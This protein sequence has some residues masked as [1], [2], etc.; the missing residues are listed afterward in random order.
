M[1]AKG[2][3]ERELLPLGGMA[4]SAKGAPSAANAKPLVFHPHRSDGG[5]AA[6][7]SR[8]VA[9]DVLFD[10]ASRGRYATDASIYQV[11]PVGVLVPKNIDDVRAAIA[12]CREHRGAG[13]PPRRGQLAVRTDGGRR[14][15]DRHHQASRPHHRIR[16][17]GDDRARRAGRRARS[18]QRLAETPRPVVPRRRQHIGAGDPRRHGGQQLL[19][20]PLDR[21][22][23]HGAQRARHRRGALRRH[24]GAVRTGTRDGRRFA[25]CRRAPPR[26]EG[27][28]SARARRNRAPR[29][30]G[31]APGRRLQHRRV[32][33]AER[34]AVHGRRQRQL[35]A[36]PGR[37]RG[38]ARLDARADA[39]ARA[40]A[41]APDAR[42]RQFPDAVPGDGMRAAPGRAAALRGRAGRPDDDRPG[43]R[44][45][46]V[47]RGHRACAARGA[48]RDPARRIHR[49]DA[50]RSP[51]AACAISSR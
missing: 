15:G 33:C 9:G 37:Q 20:L 22:R 11:E 7:L 5:L 18:A 35:C 51:F 16:S 29:A 23:Q 27:D 32:L 17:R 3:P 8:A 13:A 49:G 40:P 42:R 36:P 50:R 38:H 12:I 26:A 31:A 43:A 19:R 46:R 4:R 47:P 48:G 10:A 21:V 1:S 39:A 41:G 25:A 30:Q 34:A 24:R 2:R 45:S 6:R 14:A 44:Q 28:R